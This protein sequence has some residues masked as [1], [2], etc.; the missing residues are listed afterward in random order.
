MIV[1]LNDISKSTF[2]DNLLDF[3]TIPNL[4]ALLESVIAFLV[5]KSGVY[6][7]FQLS[8]QIFDASRCNKPNFFEFFNLR[9]FKLGQAIVR[10]QFLSVFSFNWVSNLAL[11]RGTAL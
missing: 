4:V 1:A 5:I 7:P 11:H 3:V 2:A 9:F 10:N 8:G 6:E